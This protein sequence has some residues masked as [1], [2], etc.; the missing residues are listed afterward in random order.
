[1]K[2]MIYI[3]IKMV[4]YKFH[5]STLIRQFALCIAPDEGRKSNPTFFTGNVNR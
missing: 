4:E 2:G 3:T 1:M 5:Y